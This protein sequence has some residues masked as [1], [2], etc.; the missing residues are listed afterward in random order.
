MKDSFYD[1]EYLS[2]FYERSTRDLMERG[3]SNCMVLSFYKSAVENNSKLDS[4]RDLGDLERLLLKY[5]REDKDV[6]I[7]YRGV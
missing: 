4:P 5:L 7:T 3:F 6:K 2:R 1:Y